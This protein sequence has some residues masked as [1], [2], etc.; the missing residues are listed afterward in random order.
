MWFCA[1]NLPEVEFRVLWFLKRALPSREE[2]GISLS[3]E[4]S[5]AT[6]SPA[7]YLLTDYACIIS[8][9]CGSVFNTHSNDFVRK[10]IERVT[11]RKRGNRFWSR[12][13]G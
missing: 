13:E 11:S 2:P 4:N 8:S 5:R 1:T 3:I 12:C 7:I 9:K 6:L 10:H